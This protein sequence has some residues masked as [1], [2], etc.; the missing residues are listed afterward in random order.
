MRTKI[1]EIDRRILNELQYDAGPSVSALGER[2]GL[3]Q[4]ACW[5]RIQRLEEDGVIKKRVALLEPDAIGCGT[6]ILA[7]VKL[8]AH[9]RAN[10]EDFGKK[11]SALPNVLECFLMLGDQDYFLKIAVKDIYDYEQFFL[12]KLASLEGVAEVRS[13]V[14]LSQIKNDTRLPVSTWTKD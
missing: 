3:S 14:A 7:N 9:G 12:R 11:I 8:S 6:L 10:L 5:R 4:A 2:V 1:D 13:A